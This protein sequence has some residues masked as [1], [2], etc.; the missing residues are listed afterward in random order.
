MSRSSKFTM[1]YHMQQMC[2]DLGL[3]AIRSDVICGD[4]K[5][6]FSIQ[7]IKSCHVEGVYSDRV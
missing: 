7:L 1:I 4:R 2:N 5:L 3:V 6:R